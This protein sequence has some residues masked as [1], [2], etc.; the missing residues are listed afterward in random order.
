MRIFVFHV[1][2]HQSVT[3][4]EEYFN[5]QLHRLTHSVSTSQPLFLVTTVLGELDYKQSAHGGRNVG[6]GRNAGFAWAG[7]HGFQLTKADL[8]IAAA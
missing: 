4:A 1:N 8:V 5:Y 7:Q 2:T 6:C 3:L